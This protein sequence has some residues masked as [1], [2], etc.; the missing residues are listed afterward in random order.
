MKVSTIFVISLLAVSLVY[1]RQ[2]TADGAALNATT[3]LD[4]Q[5]LNDGGT[6]LVEMSR[7]G[8]VMKASKIT[9][10]NGDDII[11]VVA[12]KGVLELS[13][14]THRITARKLSLDT[15]LHKAKLE[16]AT[17]INKLIG[18]KATEAARPGDRELDKDGGL[19]FC[20]VWPGV[21]VQEEEEEQL[22]V[23]P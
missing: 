18:S 15:D 11:V 17:Q 14:G 21:I 3:R 20:G 12:R 16:G 2:V 19:S 1:P 4:L 23:T 13:V 8:S 6:P 22:G 5:Y 9:L 7:H 10:S